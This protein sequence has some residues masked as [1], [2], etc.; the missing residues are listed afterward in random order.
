MDVI[1]HKKCYLW[2]FLVLNLLKAMNVTAADSEYLLKIKSVSEKD[3]VEGP[4]I[5]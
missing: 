2:F 1:T 4:R 3:D 5:P